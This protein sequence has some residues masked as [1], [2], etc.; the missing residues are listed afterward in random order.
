VSENVLTENRPPGAREN[1][2]GLYSILLINSGINNDVELDSRKFEK[3][4]K[5]VIFLREMFW[6]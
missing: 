1:G 6:D 4:G 2:G 5:M 3:L